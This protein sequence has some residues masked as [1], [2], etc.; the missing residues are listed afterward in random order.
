MFKKT[1]HRIIAAIM[2]ILALLFGGTL[3]LIYG[4]SYEEVGDES[5][6]MLERYLLSQ[7]RSESGHSHGSDEA[8]FDPPHGNPRTF[9]VS[10]FYSVTLA[11]GQAI[12]VDNGSGRAYDQ[13]ELEELARRVIDEDRE[14][15]QSGSLLYQ[16]YR[17]PNETYVAFMDTTIVSNNMNTLMRNTLI[18]GSIALVAFYFVAV[19]LARRIVA[20]LEESYNKQRQ[21]ISDAGHELKTPVSVV[22]AN[23]DLLSREIGP[24]PWLA[25][26]EY[27]NE[28]MGVLIGQLLELA[29]TENMK[30]SRE[31]LDFS[32]L[33]SGSA[34]PFESVAF[35]GGS[36]LTC[37]VKDGVY[38]NGN[39]DQLKQ[40]VAILLDN[41]VKHGK[42]DGTIELSL[43]ASY[44]SAILRIANDA[45]PLTLDQLT[46][47]FDRFYQ[48]DTVRNSE[49]GHYGLGLAIA[50]AIVASNDGRMD[51]TWED[52][53]AVFVVQLPLAGH[54]DSTR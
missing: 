49:S 24:N 10:T 23:T 21:F 44:H 14:S 54:L 19:Y 53:K 42:T 51:A 27:E 20:P 40:L 38:V 5:R 2:S 35:E 34:L 12:Q 31:K 3:A 26:I 45:D 28:R 17:S 32:R 7:L 33:V 18:F 1:R 11:D 47:L 13:D 16:V 50:K 9:D 39:A 36:R 15:G 22:A 6:R 29:R 25:N 37:S 8:P 43:K 48:V 4:M 30:A 46:H 41:A 52:G